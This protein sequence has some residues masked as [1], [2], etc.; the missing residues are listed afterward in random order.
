MKE[1]WEGPTWKHFLLLRPATAFATQVNAWDFA[2][3]SVKVL[4]LALSL[5]E[6][7]EPRQFSALFLGVQ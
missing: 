2:G 6:E 5:Q 7:K 1:K 4:F 3:G